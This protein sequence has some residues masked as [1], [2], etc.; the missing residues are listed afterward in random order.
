VSSYKKE[1]RVL[2]AVVAKENA[3]PVSRSRKI[4]TEAVVWLFFAFLFFFVF[5]I[6]GTPTK[7]EF[8]WMIGGVV[9]GV[10]ISASAI[11]AASR[12]QWPMLIPHIDFNSV[13]KRLSELK[14]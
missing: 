12:D 6:F 2:T 4:L 3:S 14:D 7:R 8:G 13:R 10:Y 5:R 1:K 11:F 9:V